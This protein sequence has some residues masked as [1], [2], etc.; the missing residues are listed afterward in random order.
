MMHI[1]WAPFCQ[2]DNEKGLSQNR[3]DQNQKLRYLF[4]FERSLYLNTGLFQA[5]RFIFKLFLD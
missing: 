3:R 5:K 4:T 1:C 2:T